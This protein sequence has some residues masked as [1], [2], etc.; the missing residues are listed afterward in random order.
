M[1]STSDSDAA[2]QEAHPITDVA[3]HAPHCRRWPWVLLGAAGLIGVYLL[4]FEVLVTEFRGTVM[5]VPA[6]EPIPDDAGYVMEDGQFLSLR[7]HWLYASEN[8]SWNLTAYYA[9]YPVHKVLEAS[10]RAV[11]I[12]DIDDFFHGDSKIRWPGREDEIPEDLRAPSESP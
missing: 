11:F 3:E 1:G 5:V 10:G 7:R 4:S 2:G 12:K 8:P 6:G 9:Y